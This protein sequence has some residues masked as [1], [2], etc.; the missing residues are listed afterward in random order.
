MDLVD[1]DAESLSEGCW[2]SKTSASRIFGHRS[3]LSIFLLQCSLVFNLQPLTYPSNRAKIAFVVNLLSGKVAQWATAV[4]E[5]QT[6]ASSSFPAFTAELKRVF[7][8]PVQSGEAASQIL[9][10]HAPLGARNLS[11]HNFWWT[12]AQMTTSSAGTWC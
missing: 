6:P 7:D 3:R 2:V 12:P 10:V 8:H 5:N 9:S 4:L 1:Q 11:L